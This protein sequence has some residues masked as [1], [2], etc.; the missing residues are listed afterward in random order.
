VGQSKGIMVWG[1][2]TRKK[3]GSLVLVEGKL[4]A[5]VY[6]ALLAKN[7]LPFKRRR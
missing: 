6:N 1:C 4:N 5:S 2:F 7:L 3:M